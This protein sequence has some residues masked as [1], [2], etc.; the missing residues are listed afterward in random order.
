MLKKRFINRND[1][2]RFCSLKQNLCYQTFPLL[3][4]CSPG[5]LFIVLFFPCQQYVSDFSNNC[6]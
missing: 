4:R 1:V 2:I 6:I 5:E 3:I